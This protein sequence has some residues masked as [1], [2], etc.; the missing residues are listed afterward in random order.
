MFCLHGYG[1]EGSRFRFLV[2]HNELSG[3][4]FIAP[5][6]PWHGHTLWNE[7]ETF[8]ISQLNEIFESI[9]KKEKID[10]ASKQYLVGFSLGARL[11]LAYFQSGIQ[12][13]N[14]IILLAPDGLKVNF[15]Y[16]LSTQTMFGKWLFKTTMENPGWLFFFLKLANALRLVNSS[17]FKFVNYYIDDKNA[18][19][20]LYQRWISLRKFKP[21]LSVCRALI[22]EKKVPVRILFGKFDRIIRSSAGKR[23]AKGME[24]LIEVREVSSGHQI[25]HEKHAAEIT[26]ALLH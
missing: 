12:P 20:L 23:F 3:F 16:W 24:E 22:N 26:R 15:W 6:L 13:F 9:C 11:S 4:C 17:I 7:G 21:N 8:T 19:R 2:N 5:D 14:K 18:R 1:E 10:F 25:L